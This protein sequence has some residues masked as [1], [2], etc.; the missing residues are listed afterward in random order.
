[1]FLGIPF[2][3]F[4]FPFAAGMARPED[5]FMN[6][7]GAVELAATD[8]PWKV[9][10]DDFRALTSSRTVPLKVCVGLLAVTLLV[11][12]SPAVKVGKLSV[13]AKGFLSLLAVGLF[14]GAYFLPSAVL[15]YPGLLA[16]LLAAGT[17]RWGRAGWSQNWP[18]VLLLGLLS[19][20][21]GSLMNSLD[22]LCER[23]VSRITAYF[24]QLGAVPALQDDGILWLWD[25]PWRSNATWTGFGVLIAV[26]ALFAWYELWTRAPA[27]HAILVMGVAVPLALGVLALR[28]TAV[29]LW[30][31]GEPG[32]LES[33]LFV[34]AFEL[35]SVPCVLVLAAA[36]DGYFRLLIQG[37]EV[38]PMNELIVSSRSSVPLREGEAAES[39]EPGVAKNWRSVTHHVAT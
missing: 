7:L 15:L 29:S 23:G 25:Q 24:L 32:A 8:G 20:L 5:T 9:W 37:R 31:R 34:W 2:I 10:I 22:P 3:A 1:M 16:S 35:L 12:R 39:E 30:S 4:L 26:L 27:W 36:L 13:L 17:W 38:V 6:L 19:P 11:R 18:A 14:V 33:P 21:P 28:E